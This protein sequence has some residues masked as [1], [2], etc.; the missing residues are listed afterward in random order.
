M[1]ACRLLFVSFVSAALLGSSV[2]A[3]PER[4]AGTSVLGGGIVDATDDFGGWFPKA[5]QFAINAGLRPNGSPYGRI[6]FVG[7]GDFAAA[8]GACPY[9]PRCEDFPNTFTKTFHLNGAVTDVNAFGN[10]VE[11]TGFLTET[12]H[13]KGDGVIFEELD[14][15]FVITATEGSSTFVLQFCLV[16]P[17][18][19]EVSKGN[20]SVNASAPAALL[21]R[22]QSQ[23]VTAGM[24][25]Q[26]PAMR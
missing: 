21:Q 17:F 20:L 12:D 8:W 25:C 13:G 2:D 26:A 19:M 6:N 18:T 15:P 23:S 22:P 11:I 3:R 4:S 24:P 5:G 1:R 9:D 7:R 16:P 14:V 10:S